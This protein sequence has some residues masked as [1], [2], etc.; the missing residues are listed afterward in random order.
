MR[1][2]LR[3]NFEPGTP[4]WA[5][6]R[7]QW[8]AL[9]LTDADM[10]KPKIAVV[11][12][13]SELS[14][15]FI[16]L[17]G[18]AAKVKE[19]VRAAGGLPFEV[20]TAA[21][22]DFITSA[23]HRGG[24]ILPS[25]DLIA[26]DIEV[27]VEGA[28]LDGMVCLASCDKTTPGQIMAAGRL[29]IPTMVVICGYQM[30]GAWRGEH[31]DI[32]E[33][34][35]KSTYVSTGQVTAEELQGMSDNAV[36]G[37][38]VCAGMGTA[39]SMHVVCEALGMSLP[40]SAPVLANSP[41]MMDF[42][43][44]SGERIVHMVWEDLK[45][46]DILTREAFENAV[47]AVLALSGSINCVKH[48][49]AIAVEA[50]CDVDIYALFEH[51]AGKVPLLAGI[52]PNGERLIE[53]LE[54]AGGARAVMKQLEPMLCGNARS[55]SGE[56]V[57]QILRDVRVK[58]EEII[59]PLDRP[60]S[61]RPAI[62]IVRGSLAPEGG[63]V[64][65]GGEGERKLKFSGL[66]TIYHSREESL[67]A[68][69]KGEIRAGQVVVL[70][71]M[72]VKGGPGMAMASAL[73]FAL[74]GAGLIEDVAVVTDGQLSGLVN[75]GLVVGEVSPEA[76]A[77]GPLALAENGDTITIDVERREVNLE[78][79]EGELA[80]RRSRMGQFAGSEERGWLSQY[81]RTVQPLRKGAVL[82]KAP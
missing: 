63:I 67:E 54:A 32:E 16:H 66:A 17:D 71:G 35:L 44:R 70:R 13:S 49:Q 65:L 28:L 81:E 80:A 33:V 3:S 43:R 60:L 77:G 20:R 68:L 82:S 51:H 45:P 2:K 15:C 4:R 19:A 18:V 48:L 74:D 64:R 31:V 5:V 79:G 58:D 52:R 9:G 55:V 23:G 12:S 39:N 7:A 59:R 14:S 57:A 56:T 62:V 50:G 61:R 47:I 46:R 6:R 24:Y 8:R 1:K 76:V 41:A 72:G 27:A 38:G 11:N 40:G 22:S 25:R 78:V 36:L 29:N 30:S 73:V 21:P 10:E 75:R 37:P 34:F 69:R 42:V 53:E 26:N